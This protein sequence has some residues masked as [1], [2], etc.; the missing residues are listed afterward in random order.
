MWEDNLL[1]IKNKL[2]IQIENSL[3][4]KIIFDLNKYFDKDFVKQIKVLQKETKRIFN[5]NE[6]KVLRNFYYY[7]NDSLLHALEVKNF[8]KINYVGQDLEIC[9]QNTIDR[10]EK[11]DSEKILNSIK[12]RFSN[13]VSTNKAS[14][15]HQKEWL[16]YYE[17][18]RKKLFDYSLFV[19]RITN[20]DYK[21]HG[22]DQY[23]FDLIKKI[24]Q[25]LENYRH[26]IIVC[27]GQIYDNFGND[28]TWKLVYKLTIYCENFVQFD[29]KYSQFH[30]DLLIQELGKFIQTKL[31]NCNGIESLIL[32]SNFY[33]NISCGF[34]FEDCLVSEK[35]EKI[36]IILKKIQLDLSPV[37]CPACFTTIQSGNS[38]PELFLRSYECKN[39]E[40]PERSKSGRG[41]RFDEYGIYRSLKLE[42]GL[43][44]NQISNVE[45]NKWHRDIFDSNYDYLEMIIKY[46]AWNSETILTYNINSLGNEIQSRKIKKFSEGISQ[47]NFKPFINNYNDLPIVKLF[48]EINR[49]IPPNITKVKNISLKKIEVINADSTIEINKLSKKI[50]GTAITSPPY[51]NAREYSQWS[52]LI[53]YLIDMM[54]NAKSIYNVLDKNGYYLYNIGDIVDQDNIYIKSHM[55][56]RR[57]PLGFLSCMIFEI[58]GYNLKEN[59]LWDKGEVQ[60]KRN[61]TINLYPGYVK[62][63]NC[64]E[65]ILVFNKSNNGINNKKIAKFNPVIKINSKGENIYKHSAPYPL[66]LVELIRP[67]IIKNKYI[68]DPFLGSGTTLIWC[69]QNNFKGIGFE[70]NKE[71]FELSKE[72]IDDCK[73]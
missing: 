13:L 47:E 2:N 27:D 57:L 14:E 20:E 65:H 31:E 60:S 40:C 4:I 44:T 16:A 36:I 23:L 53:F 48:T 63:I 17:N 72:K 42:E 30:K 38:F 33:K 54:R 12:K 43:Q 5:S 22:D 73:N 9:L 61:S 19:L 46:Y 71:Y 15:S 68:L 50:V 64:Y 41:K 29:E 58:V 51:Y 24:Y 69:A 45:Y 21:K 6:R 10:L 37:P 39:S 32:A 28:I 55:S 52:T 35:Q 3:L 67:Y 11:Y 70:L 62:P 49:L 26:L 7:N 1:K 18:K 8:A 34:K 59:I 56:N 66:D 25:K